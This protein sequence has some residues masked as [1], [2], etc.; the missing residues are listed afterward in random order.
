MVC[1]L[2]GWS[3]LYSRTVCHTCK[4]L[5]SCCFI[6]C[7]CGRLIFLNGLWSPSLCGGGYY[8]CV[9]LNIFSASFS[10]FSFALRRCN[11]RFCDRVNPDG[12]HRGM[13][14]F[15]SAILLTV[16]YFFVCVGRFTKNHRP[17][18]ILLYDDICHSY[19]N[20]VLFYRTVR[21]CSYMPPCQISQPLGPSCSA[22]L[23]G[24]CS[25]TRLRGSQSVL[26][27]RRQPSK[28]R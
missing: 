12:H 23:L 22:I 24:L 26:Y 28:D 16:V 6:F 9:S 20:D 1:V 25:W 5:H 18:V 19:F 17:F 13:E 27:W 15:E 7:L 11:F 8:R 3:G 10:W 21:G 14:Y 2:Y 4:E